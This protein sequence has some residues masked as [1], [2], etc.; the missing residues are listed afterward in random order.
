MLRA[1]AITVKSVEVVMFRNQMPRY[2]ILSQ[3]AIA[4]LERGWKR[5]VS[6]VGIQFAKPEAI[7]LFKAAGQS[8]EDDVVKLD[9]D[10]I[11]EQVAKAPAEFDVQARNPA[12]NVHVG[13]DQMAFGAV[14]GSPFIR[15]GEVR[16][17]ATLED[18][19]KLAML[20]QSFAELDSAGGVICEPNDAPLDSRHL[21]MIY[22]LQTLTDKIYMGNVVSGP[23]AADTI[24]MTEILFG[25]SDGKGR[26]SIEATPAT[27]SLIN[28][29]SP[30][31]WDDRMLDAQFEYCAA[32]QPVVLTPFLLMGAMSPVTIPAALTQQLAEAL[33][34]IALAQLIR[35]GCPVIFGSFLSNI[36]MQSGSPS[37]GTPESAIGLF[38]TGQ[39]ARHYGLP[40]RT[41]GGLTSSQTCDA[42]AAYESLMTLLPTFLAGT[43]FVMH[44]AGWLE[45]GLVS[46]YEKFIVDIELLRMLRVEFTPLEI[47]EESLAFGAHVEVGHGGHFLGAEHTMERFRECFYRP[48]LSSTANYERWLKLGGKDATARAA[49]IA[50]KKLDEYVAPPLDDAIRAEL[51]DF[52]ARRRT[53]LGD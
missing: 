35:P 2:E 13:G 9:P 23:N 40:F 21:D 34:G 50:A 49:E 51:E 18:F 36:D 20:S 48:L 53:E 27:I 15:E 1:P 37:F 38:C 44:A 10:F 22:A 42:Q 41:G 7:E 14:Y 52:V 29:N 17:D 8:V 6:E 24:K 5:I 11:L 12:N 33:S 19:R 4:V 47:D 46:C 32:N 31:R 25:G 39:L 3:D 16:R 43:N 28:C 26:A 45:G 30:L